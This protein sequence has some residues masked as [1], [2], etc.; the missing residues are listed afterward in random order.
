MYTIRRNY[1]VSKLYDI[2]IIGKCG[3]GHFKKLKLTHLPSI[4]TLCI[5]HLPTDS[6]KADNV[7]T[8]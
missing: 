6:S 3:I 1:K 7:S 4:N 5:L 8:K 2:K